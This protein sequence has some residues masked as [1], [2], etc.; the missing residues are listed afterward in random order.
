M[1]QLQWLK[2]LGSTVTKPFK[3]IIEPRGDI[4][5]TTTG[6]TGVTDSTTTKR[7]LGGLGGRNIFSTGNT[8][9]GNTGV[10]DSTTGNTG[11]TDSTT[12]N[13]VGTDST[14][15]NNNPISLDYENLNN[16]TTNLTSNI[17]D[18]NTAGA[19]DITSDKGKTL[20]KDFMSMYPDNDEMLNKFNVSVKALEG[21]AT[22]D[23]EAYKAT[24][25]LLDR[26]NASNA[27]DLISNRQMVAMDP[28]MTEGARRAAIAGAE[29]EAG[30]RRDT[31]AGD[32]AKLVQEQAL[33]AA[34]N[35]GTLSLDY[36]KYTDAQFKDTVSTIM[37]QARNALDSKIA[38]GELTAAQA[39]IEISRLNSEETVAYHNRYLE[40][41]SRKVA[42]QE[43]LEK[44]ELEKVQYDLMHTR[45]TDA[46]KRTERG[47]ISY[48]DSVETP[49][50]KDYFLTHG[51]DLQAEWEANNPGD[52]WNSDGD[53]E[54]EWAKQ[55]FKETTN[56]A[57]SIFNDF[58]ATVG[59]DSLVEDEQ[60]AY[61]AFY[62][63][64]RINGM[65]GGNVVENK[66]GSFDLKNAS[67]EILAHYDAETNALEI[68]D[69]GLDSPIN[70]PG[71]YSATAA[72]L[73]SNPDINK[74]LSSVVE[75]K[76]DEGNITYKISIPNGYEKSFDPDTFKSMQLRAAEYM[77]ETDKVKYL[78][79]ATTK[80]IIQLLDIG[81][82]NGKDIIDKYGFGQD[83]DGNG[84]SFSV[85]NTTDA[86]LL[87]ELYNS[88]HITV[89]EY[90]DVYSGSVKVGSYG[91]I[92][93]PPIELLSSEHIINNPEI[94]KILKDGAFDL[95]DKPLLIYKD[96]N[97]PY[98]DERVDFAFPDV[99]STFY[100]PKV[101][102]VDGRYYLINTALRSGDKVKSKASPKIE[103]TRGHFVGLDNE[104]VAE[105]S[106]TD[107]E[108][109][110]IKTLTIDGDSNAVI[111]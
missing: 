64:I 2:D 13:N 93:S 31:L 86:G 36:M 45:Q 77:G 98:I 29:R 41:E 4:S 6:N 109:G 44:A 11:V 61:K 24:L 20:V 7:I 101:V 100:V 102:E 14:T 51:A 81:A 94:I 65:L 63:G 84:S 25:N 105:Y 57:E 79:E 3:G 95:S 78:E 47:I 48:K 66:D 5:T 90:N 8:T 37:T 35:L 10:T 68:I 111:K 46:S 17:A 67:G 97:V 60:K 69:L 106:A 33:T 43:A 55:R 18:I 1:A 39:Q 38:V 107:I 73:A 21:M 50:F 52:V 34:S 15:G 80:E 59:W 91:T 89:D 32:I 88:G 22:G 110:D 82:I 85:F 104:Y 28:T 99:L 108:S 103:T 75:E 96:K 16:I 62:D 74:V 40:L 12:G 27:T 53:P 30:I 9:T 58:K 70:A 72:T 54:V 87:K 83:G 92:T 76:D 23:P 49:N 19:F 71:I 56:L 26:I 42:S